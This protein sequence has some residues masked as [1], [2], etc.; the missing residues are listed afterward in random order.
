MRASRSCANGFTYVAWLID[1]I[2]FLSDVHFGANRVSAIL[3]VISHAMPIAICQAGIHVRT[4][5]TLPTAVT[6][7]VVT[8]LIE[9]GGR[10]AKSN[11]FI[12]LQT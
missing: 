8:G 11:A 12:F 3:A 4:L 2:R 10:I 7:G 9:S 5:A 1:A 6:V